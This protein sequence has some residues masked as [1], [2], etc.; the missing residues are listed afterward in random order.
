MSLKNQAIK[1]AK[2]TSISTVVVTLLQLVQLTILSRIL[3]PSAFGLMAMVTVIVGLAQAFS[4]MGISNALIQKQEVSKK[5]L[6]SLYWVN[7][8]SGWLVFL[9]IL[10]AKPLIISFFQKPELDSMINLISCIFL[11]IPIGQQFQALLQKELQFNKLAIITVSSTILGT[12]V[13]VATALQGLGVYSLVW[14]QIA[15]AL[16][17]T[18]AFVVIGTKNFKPSLHFAKGDLHGFLSFGLFQMGDRLI[19]YLNQNL[20]YIIIGRFLGAEALG[21]Y[22]LAYNLVV[23]PVTKINPIINRVAFPVFSKIQNE[24]DKLKKGYL[25]VLSLLSLINFPLYFGLFVTAPLFIP[26]FYGERWLPSVVLTQV[27]CGVGFFRSIANPVGSLVMAKGRAG[28]SFRI[29]TVKTVIQFPVLLIGAIYY[30]V[31]GVA[32]AYF[33][34]KLIFAF[35]N[36]RVFIHK[37]L[38]PCLK[39]YLKSMAP[40]FIIS[41]AMAIFVWF[42]GFYLSHLS[43]Y[44]LFT[45]EVLV[46]SLLYF[47][48]LKKF[49]PDRMNDLQKMIFKKK[50]VKI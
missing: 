47:I 6:S 42:I 40:S 49:V 25:Q 11:I 38:G 16:V 39:E 13:A 34:L 14:G 7:I 24:L 50:G 27:L 29:N 36:Y 41:M 28:L 5:Q 2:W 45:I 37:L 31:L 33:L 19:T 43:N 44:L 9:L 32:I 30:N 1:G 15:N 21:Y 20:D 12:I 8:G 10:L 23:L 46:G 22:T 26:I 35:I 18:V 17:Q 48:L 3:D 4:D